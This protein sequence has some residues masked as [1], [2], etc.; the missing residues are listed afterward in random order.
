MA[1]RSR[2]PKKAADEKFYPIRVRI[3]V[4]EEGFGY[5]LDDIHAWLNARAGRGRWGWNGDNVFSRTAQDAVSV[6]LLD[7]S[8]VS[9]LVERFG[10]ELAIADSDLCG[11]GSFNL[12]KTTVY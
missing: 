7:P 6:Y 1:T 10:L 9:E 11:Q 12:V 8:L 3:Q 2:S 4:P 5:R